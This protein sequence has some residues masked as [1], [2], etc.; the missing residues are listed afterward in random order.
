MLEGE[1]A[2]ILSS[3]N[4]FKYPKNNTHNMC[5]VIEMKENVEHFEE[6]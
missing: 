1:R 4:C 6:E 5:E 2:L 3:I